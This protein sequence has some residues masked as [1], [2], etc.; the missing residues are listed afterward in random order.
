MFNDLDVVLYR[1]LTML[2]YRIVALSNF[3]EIIWKHTPSF[4]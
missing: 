4:S 2:S 3:I 1:L